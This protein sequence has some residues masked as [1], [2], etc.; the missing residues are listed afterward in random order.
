M[1]AS[2]YSGVGYLG[3][4]QGLRR[5]SSPGFD[6]RL[7]TLFQLYRHASASVIVLDFLSP[8]FQTD[9]CSIPTKPLAAFPHHHHQKNNQR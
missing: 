7:T 4:I 3:L 1:F 6:H 9:V 5:F 2:G 8:L